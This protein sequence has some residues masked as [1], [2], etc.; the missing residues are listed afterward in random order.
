M[1]LL[2]QKNAAGGSKYFSWVVEVL[3]SVDSR[4]NRFEVIPANLSFFIL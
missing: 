1:R 4:L 2:N 3:G